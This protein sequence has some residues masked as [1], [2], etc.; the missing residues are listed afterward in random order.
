MLKILLRMAVLGIL[1]A[2]AS[3]RAAAQDGD[4]KYE[5]GIRSALI[6]GTMNLS[7]L[8]PAFDD[9]EPDGAKGAHMSGFFLMYKVK[10]YLRLGVET[11]VA[12]SD[13]TAATTMNYQAAGPVVELSYGTSWF[14][15]GGLHAGG[16]VVNA[17]A[18]EG[19]AP[20]DGASSGSFFKGEG[21]FVAPYADIGY[22]YRRAELGL[23][24][25]QVN[26][27]G[28]A[29]R[30]GMSEFGSKF[31]GLRFAIAL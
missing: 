23:F 5:A 1:A 19:A 27:S 16:L 29:E 17:M 9:L 10:P 8:D 28:E 25:K 22:R 15:S 6:V 3:K 26:I 7:G 2:T 18:R 31:V 4:R 12:N 13:K 21:Y 30:G 14:V 11:L 20:V 24:I